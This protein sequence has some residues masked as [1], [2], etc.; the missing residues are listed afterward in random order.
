[1]LVPMVASRLHRMRPGSQST[2]LADFS[3]LPRGLRQAASSM[4]RAW[5]LLARRLDV[6]VLNP[7][8]P[9]SGPSCTAIDAPQVCSK[10]QVARFHSMDCVRCAGNAL[11]S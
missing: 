7:V 4:L 2:D 5:L 8:S 6:E 11:H 9:C 1:M 10:C 3:H